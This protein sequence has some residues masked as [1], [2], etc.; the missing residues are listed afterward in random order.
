M[1]K[2]KLLLTAVALSLST[3]LYAQ[4]QKFTGTVVDTNGEPI[5]GATIKVKG[6]NENA[7]T[8]IDGNFSIAANPGQTLVVNYIGFSQLET[9]VANNMK[10]TLSEDR[11]TLNDIVVVGYG[12]QKKSVVTASIAKVSADDLS[13]TAPVRVDNALKGLAAGVTVTSASGN[14]VLH[15][16]CAFVVSAQSTTPT[17]YTLSTECLLRVV[18]IILIRATLSQSRC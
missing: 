1:S 6:S 18:L 9:K 5:I 8:D 13:G 2:S 7:I 10:L 16:R 11:Q 4:N 12:V 14:L 3:S 17:H 15:L